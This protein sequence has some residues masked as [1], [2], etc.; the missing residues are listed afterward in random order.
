MADTRGW[1]VAVRGLILGD[2]PVIDLC[3]SRSTFHVRKCA[4]TR[5][6]VVDLGIRMRPVIAIVNWH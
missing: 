4:L 5:S 2:S 1:Q 6:V 3:V